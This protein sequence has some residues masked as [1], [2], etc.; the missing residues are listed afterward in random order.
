MKSLF[1]TSLY[2]AN[3]RNSERVEVSLREFT[4]KILSDKFLANCEMSTGSAVSFS[5]RRGQ[6]DENAKLAGLV[7]HCIKGNRSLVDPETN[8]IQLSTD[9]VVMMTTQNHATIHNLARKIAYDEH[10]SIIQG[11]YDKLQEKLADSANAGIAT[12][13]I[14]NDVSIAAAKK[15]WLEQGISES[16]IDAFFETQPPEYYSDT[17]FTGSTIVHNIYSNYLISL[18][19]ELRTDPATVNHLRNLLATSLAK[20]LIEKIKSVSSTSDTEIEKLTDSQFIELV[21]KLL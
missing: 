14:L 5:N 7:L 16:D 3:K 8:K 10:D 20:A 9:A 17:T 12:P 13:K 4:S 19:E 11:F 2:E 18:V 1:F 15:A 6:N 21:Q